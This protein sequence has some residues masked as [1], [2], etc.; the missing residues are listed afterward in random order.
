MQKFALRAYLAA[1]AFALAPASGI[2]APQSVA[3]DQSPAAS[4]CP[5]GN[6][7]GTKTRLVDIDFAENILFTDKGRLFVTGR[8][9]VFE[10]VRDSDPS[11]TGYRANPTY[12][13]SDAFGGMA[14]IGNMLYAVAYDGGLYTARLDQDP[15]TLQL[16]HQLS[17]TTITNGMAAGP[18]GELYI[19]N[20]PVTTDFQF[21]PKI[22]RVRFDANDPMT[23]VE[24]TDWLTKGLVI[25]N[26]LRRRGRTL[27]VV[28]A[29]LKPVELGVIKTVRINTDG[30]AGKP[31][32]FADVAKSP[33]DDMALTRDGLLAAIFFGRAI[34]KVD[35]DGN[36]VAQTPAG[37]F[38][39]PSSVA[40]GRPP[41]FDS[42]VWLVTEKGALFGPGSPTFG[43]ALSM[44]RPD[45]SK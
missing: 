28:D 27:Y 32:L 2:C 39:N 19:T 11:G 45:R 25:P 24:Q 29:T 26:G 3:V 20:G 8:S 9:N 31:Q 38:D 13:G 33:L 30:T 12:A 23:V 16:I 34:A 22:L 4:P 6:I 43:N 14:Q 5:Q 37:T 17:G 40:I 7:C 1:F 44:F 35:F 41:L 36:V 15:I 21:V 10:I 42:S 18:D